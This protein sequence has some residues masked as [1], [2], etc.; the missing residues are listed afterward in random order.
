MFA[1]HIPLSDVNITIPCCR[2]VTAECCRNTSQPMSMLNGSPLATMETIVIV[3]LW[4]VN[5]NDTCFLTVL[6][7]LPVAPI[8]MM[9]LIGRVGI[10]ILVLAWIRSSSV[11]FIRDMFDLVSIIMIVIVPFIVART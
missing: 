3:K 8:M 6:F 7:C 5:S 4:L 1:D 10:G 9:L 2:L 11:W